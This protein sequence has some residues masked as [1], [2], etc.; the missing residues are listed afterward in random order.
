[1]AASYHHN[2]INGL[3]EYYEVF[4]NAV[5]AVYGVDAD[6]AGV[7]SALEKLR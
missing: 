6:V 3:F 1:M 4:R 2:S 7:A 5:V